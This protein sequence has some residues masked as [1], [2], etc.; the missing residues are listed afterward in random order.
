MFRRIAQSAWKRTNTFQKRTNKI[1]EVGKKDNAVA[2]MESI[3]ADTPTS[4][5][6]LSM[7]AGALFASLG[8]YLLHEEIWQSSMG[9]AKSVSGLTEIKTKQ[10]LDKV[11]IFLHY[12]FNIIRKLQN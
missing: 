1:V 2:S 4:S 12:F 7:T 8:Y 9:L 6:I 3:A 5:T 11:I 10:Q